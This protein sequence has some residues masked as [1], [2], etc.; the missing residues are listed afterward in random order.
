MVK[1][2]WRVLRNPRSK[3]TNFWPFVLMGEPWAAVSIRGWSEEFRVTFG[4]FKER[5]KDSPVWASCY[6]HFQLLAMPK[7]FAFWK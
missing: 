7:Q 2:Q 5:Q 1:I 3:V 6:R 4:V